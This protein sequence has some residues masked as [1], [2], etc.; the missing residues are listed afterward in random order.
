MN[1]L[2]LIDILANKM[3][4]SKKEATIAIETIFGTITD[5]LKRDEEINVGGFGAFRVKVRAARIGINPKSKEKIQIA[6]TRAPA[7]RPSKALKEVVKE[8]G[9]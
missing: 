1:K 5:C 8:T 9:K 3:N 6:E 7:F 2:Q 4:I